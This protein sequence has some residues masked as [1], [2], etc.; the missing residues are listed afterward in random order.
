[1]HQYKPGDD[2]GGEYRVLRVFGGEKQSGMGVVYLVHNREIPKPIVLKTFQHAV[3][4]VAKQ[5][6]MSEASA[7]IKAGVHANIV[8]A[9][10]V[11]D[12]AGQLFVA[13][14]YIEPDE[15]DRNSLA[16]FLSFGQLRVA[17]ILLW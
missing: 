5:R 1:M 16:H 15:E 8:Q 2:I 3:G 6:F 12:V 17:T 14:E 9:Y 11:R 13:A 7:W 4:E 10:W